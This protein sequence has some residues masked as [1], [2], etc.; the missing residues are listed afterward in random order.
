MVV[1][2]QNSDLQVE[3]ISYF[4]GDLS[5]SY[6]Y[7]SKGAFEF[8]NTYDA[9]NAT[10][11]L[12]GR[13]QLNVTNSNKTLSA[14]D[15]QF[16]ITAVKVEGTT[17][18]TDDE[19]AAN[20]IPMPVLNG[21][22]VKIGQLVG[23]GT[24][25]LIDFGTITFKNYIVN[26]EYTYVIE[27]EAPAADTNGYSY[28][29]SAKELTIRVTEDSTD[30]ALL[31]ASPA[32]D[33]DPSLDRPNSWFLF[34]NSYEPSPY[35]TTGNDLLRVDKTLSGR[36][37][38]N[39][40]F[41]FELTGLNGAPVPT[42][43]TVTISGTNESDGTTLNTSFGAITYERAGT[44]NYEIREAK[45]N[46][47]GI[48][49]DS[50]VVRVQ[51]IVED[52][53]GSLKVVSTSYDNDTSATASAKFVNTY[54]AS[55]TGTI[56]V[57]KNIDGRDFIETDNKDTGKGAF[58]FTLAAK[59]DYGTNVTMPSGLV[60]NITFYD[61]EDS[62][63]LSDNQRRDTFDPI[64]FNKPGTY[65]F[66]VQE[67]NGS[68]P[69]IT[70]DTTVK[71]VTFVVEDNYDGTLKV[72]VSGD[73]DNNALVQVTNTYEPEDVTTSGNTLIN[74]QKTINGRDWLNGEEIEFRIEAADSTPDAPLP[75]SQEVTVSEGDQ[76]RTNTGSFGS[77]TYTEAGEYKYSVTE[78]TGS[79]AGLKYSLGEYEV[80]VNVIDDQEEGKL[81][82]ESITYN[83]VKDID[84]KTTFIGNTGIARFT[85]TYRASQNYELKVHKDLNGRGDWLTT[86]S[87]DFTLSAGNSATVA[88]VES[89][90]VVL[91][92]DRLTISSTTTDKTASFGN[93][94]F[95]KTGN[96]S[97]IVTEVNGGLASI[98]YAQPQTVN[99]TVTD[100]NYNGVLTVVAKV[101]TS[102]VQNNTLT[103]VNTYT[104]DAVSAVINVDKTVNGKNWANGDSFT[105]TLATDS[106]DNL[107][108]AAVTN[109]DVVLPDNK[110]VTIAYNTEGNYVSSFG[111]ITFNKEGTYKFTVTENDLSNTNWS[112]TDPVKTVTIVVEDNDQGQL[113]LQNAVNG[114]YYLSFTNLFT[115]DP[116][117]VNIKGTKTMTGREL[118]ATDVFDFTLTAVDGAPMPDG[119]VM[120]SKTVQNNLSVID[121]GNIAYDQAGVYNYQ[122]TE[123][124][125]DDENGV[126]SDS[127][128][129]NV[130]VTVTY[131]P[132]NGI[133][134][135]EIT[136]SKQ[137][138][139]DVVIWRARLNVAVKE[140]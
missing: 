111:E 78:V 79:T 38:H 2:P 21:Q 117:S 13:K 66:T 6:D 20:N 131:D 44:Y 105:F 115:P 5:T 11:N 54:R 77:I 112:N 68:I 128:T 88:A 138:T 18:T 136:Y 36:N 123:E 95:N 113:V 8:T 17:Y 125:I 85:N 26:K 82:I 4:K 116:V 76:A 71:E 130:T 118:E 69:G 103:F 96:Y 60:K 73:T 23:N 98:E 81:V 28:D 7:A 45:G 74:V 135:P 104:A 53:N 55:G 10:F 30:G 84:G 42:N 99:F 140:G 33:L 93:I 97:F 110:Q 14:N 50:H 101:G 24:D 34:T 129:I 19:I 124:L 100:E 29:R 80:I 70:Y 32:N 122:I 59:T 41:E 65:A 47:N 15:F 132:N 1:A 121:F 25:T 16:K 120:T 56:T 107:T 94:T 89:G 72:T 133:L 83:V 134:S 35:T 64:A 40:S 126:T 137:E 43:N 39:D 51:V 3:D 87:F 90:D 49:Y 63:L 52:D 46:N 27:E 102:D 114:S 91:H 37:W 58:V 139:P 92:S 75:A 61:D 67:S 109:G 9:D 57:Q 106:S 48:T 119:S 62:E 12:V 31:V 108:S 86:D 127:T 22:T